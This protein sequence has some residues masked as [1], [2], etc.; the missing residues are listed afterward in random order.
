MRCG[1]SVESWQSVV[2]RVR[3]AV[4]EIRLQR[5]GWKCSCQNCSFFPIFLLDFFLADFVHFYTFKVGDIVSCAFSSSSSFGILCCCCWC[6]WWF[7]RM[8]SK[9]HFDGP[10]WPVDWSILLLVGR[11]C[12][13][14]CANCIS[15]FL[16][17]FPSLSL[18]S[19]SFLSYCLLSSPFLSFFLSFSF[20]VVMRICWQEVKHMNGRKHSEQLTYVFAQCVE[21]L[22]FQCRVQ[23][24]IFLLPCVVM[25]TFPIFFFFSSS[26]DSLTLTLTLAFSFDSLGFFWFIFRAFGWCS[27]FR[28]RHHRTEQMG[29]ICSKE[30]MLT[31]Q[32]HF[33]R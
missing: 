32:T 23:S 1:V 6:C 33:H 5:M 13:S 24:F 20:A 2:K 4:F 3:E 9:Y 22:R 12:G 29:K 30:V 10:V 19:F 14:C 11:E 25:I 21:Y 18:F 31:S 8:R 16:C 17:L 27:L 7:S 26:F 15:F 28:V